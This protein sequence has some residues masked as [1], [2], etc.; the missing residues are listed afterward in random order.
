MAQTSKAHIAGVHNHPKRMRCLVDNL[1][2]LKAGRW[3]PDPKSCCIAAL[4]CT[5]VLHAPFQLYDDCL[6]RQ[7]IQERLGVD[8]DCL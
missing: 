8:G 5:F 6:A 7:V 1:R 4:V 3:G 2:R